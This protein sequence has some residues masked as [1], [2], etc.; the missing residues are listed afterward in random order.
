MFINFKVLLFKIEG[1]YELIKMFNKNNKF[2][3]N[4]IS[5]ELE[6]KLMEEINVD[7]MRSS[8]EVQ[9]AKCEQLY[10]YMVK[11][12]LDTLTKMKEEYNAEN[13]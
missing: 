12:H 1:S 10:K 11:H 9:K 8:N 2:F 3:S 7:S 5:D 13:A 4:F 6:V